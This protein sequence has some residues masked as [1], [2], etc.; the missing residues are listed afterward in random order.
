MGPQEPTQGSARSAIRALEIARYWQSFDE[1]E[2]RPLRE[3]A[4]ATERLR[5]SQRVEDIPAF[6]NEVERTQNVLTP[7]QNRLHAQS[8]K[9]DHVAQW[10]STQA[11]K[12]RSEQLKR[13]AGSLQSLGKTLGLGEG[14]TRELGNYLSL[15]REDALAALEAAKGAPH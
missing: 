10:V 6:L 4:I 13:A 14:S 7:L 5:R 1:K 12:R 2:M 9:L 15:C 11:D 3:L 8:E